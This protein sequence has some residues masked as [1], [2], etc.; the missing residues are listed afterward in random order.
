MVQIDVTTTE[1][2]VEMSQ[3]VKRELHSLF[4]YLHS[5]FVDEELTSTISRHFTKR[6]AAHLQDLG[7]LPSRGLYC[8]ACAALKVYPQGHAAFCIIL[9]GYL[10]L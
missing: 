2:H 3:Y 1:V 8:V 9:K 6:V 4:N 10:V 7:Q 5:S